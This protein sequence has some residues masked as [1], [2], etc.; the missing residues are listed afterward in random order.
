MNANEIFKKLKTACP[1]RNI[2]IPKDPDFHIEEKTLWVSFHS[3]DFRDKN[4]QTDTAAFEGWIFAL[5]AHK[6]LLGFDTVVLEALEPVKKED[7]FDGSGNLLS[8]PGNGHYGRFLYR[9][10]RFRE[11]YIWFSLRGYLKD[12]VDA[13]EAYIKTKTFF[14]ACSEKEA[15]VKSNLE[16]L[17]ESYFAGEKGSEDLNR[18][19]RF[20]GGLQSCCTAFYRQLL[21]GLYE[22]GSKKA[23]FT[24]GGTSAADLWSIADSTL[25][26]F[27]LKTKSSSG[28][29]N[30][31]IGAATEIFF[32][33]NYCFDLFVSRSG[34]FIPVPPKKSNDS[35][36]LLMEARERGALQNVK[37]FLL[38]DKESCHPLIKNLPKDEAV[39][40]TSSRFIDVMNASCQPKIQY[41][42]LIYDSKNKA[43]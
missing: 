32:Y 3:L 33:S 4:M 10:L 35:Y 27:E 11:Q 21:V 13:F 26:P 43:N 38:L 37:G 19:L 29:G 8:V 17:Q 6:E 28:K 22:S 30:F 41:G 34:P 31:K 23:V 1:K 12:A 5:Y 24:G 2:R 9:A 20:Q 25:I 14:N 42:L 36:R 7:L 15:E 18:L 40:D 16:S 39:T